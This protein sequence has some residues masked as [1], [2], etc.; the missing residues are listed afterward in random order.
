MA[1]LTKRRPSL[2]PDQLG[3]TFEAPV[4]P[5]RAADLAGLDRKVSA[6]VSIALK[7]DPRSREEIAGAVSALLDEPVS[8]LMLDAYASEAREGHAISLARFLA[9]VAVTNRHDLLDTL[10][11]EVGAAVLVGEE[12]L[13]ARL[14]DIKTRIAALTQEMRALERSA[15]PI[16]RAN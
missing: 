4:V 15:T 10:T 1:G 14:G 7:D 13:T 2:H 9:L 12:L 16:G 3:F 11:R 8:K 5:R 6:A